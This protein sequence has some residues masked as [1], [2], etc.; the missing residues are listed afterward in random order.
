MER[1]TTAG[2]YRRGIISRTI[3]SE[4]CA[5]DK[6][7]VEVPEEHAALPRKKACLTSQQLSNVT[8]APPNA[9]PHRKRRYF[10]DPEGNDRKFVQSI[11]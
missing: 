11:S 9:H 10:Y 1:D 2:R 3:S 7:N 6:H 4:C 8:S 5:A